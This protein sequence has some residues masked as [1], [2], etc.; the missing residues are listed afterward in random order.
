MLRKSRLGQHT[1]HSRVK[2]LVVIVGD[3]TVPAVAEKLA[4]TGNIGRDYRLSEDQPLGDKGTEA[5]VDR[6]TYKQ[7]GGIH[8][9]VRIL[10][11]AEQLRRIFKVIFTDVFLKDRAI[12]AL[13]DHPQIVVDAFRQQP[14]VRRQSANKIFGRAQPADRSNRNPALMHITRQR[15]RRLPQYLGIVNRI[16]NSDRIDRIAV[17]LAKAFANVF[18]NTNGI[19]VA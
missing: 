11:E 6:R 1:L 7:I 15:Q 9:T 19:V 16:V 2:R 4:H 12:L 18:G 14:P 5:L 13:S 8:E 17:K 3:K 10:T